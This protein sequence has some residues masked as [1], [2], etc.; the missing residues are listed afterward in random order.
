MNKIIAKRSISDSLVKLEIRTD[1]AKIEFYPGQY[2]NLRNKKNDAAIALP[3]VKADSD[4]ETITVIVSATDDNSRNL[5]GLIVGSE[6]FAIDGPLGDRAQIGNYGTVLCIGRG[7]GIVGLLPVLVALRAAGNQIITILSARTAEGIILENEVKAISE[8]VITLTDDGSY[9]EK[10]QVCHS[11]GKLLRYRK[12]DHVLAVGSPK[13]IK[14]TC[15]VTTKYNVPSQ[16]VLYLDKSAENKMHGIFKV[17]ILGSAKAVCV[18]GH[19][20]N[21]YFANLEEMVKR[22][23]T[24]DIETSRTISVSKKIAV[25]A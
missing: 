13:T 1:T 5:A 6:L 11:M 23:V 2:V 24:E 3:V 10:E 16:A 9:G 20:F 15:S 8:E 4:R 21:A 18:D 7:Q 25:P 14:E 19:N 17:S 22:F 12:F